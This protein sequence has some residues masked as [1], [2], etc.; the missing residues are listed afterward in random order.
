MGSHFKTDLVKSWKRGRKILNEFQEMFTNQYLF[1][2]R[3][4]YKHH[5]KQ[6]RVTSDKTPEI[7]DIVQIKDGSKNRINWKVGKIVS[8]LKG[9]DD[10]CRVAKVKVGNSECTPSVAHLYPLEDDLTP[11]DIT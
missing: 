3:E 9:K 4:R 8:L 7:G 1:S 5:L 10:L 11:T 6:R 2:L